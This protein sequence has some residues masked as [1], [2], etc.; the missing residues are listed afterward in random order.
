MELLQYAAWHLFAGFSEAFGLGLGRVL[1][2]L[3]GE[4]YMLCIGN[5]DEVHCHDT[6]SEA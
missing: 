5:E 4:I 2:G 1:L 6:A 3:V